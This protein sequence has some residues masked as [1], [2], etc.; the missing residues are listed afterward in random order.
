MARLTK[1]ES[2]AKKAKI[3]AMLATN[4]SWAMIVKETGCSFQTIAAI[5]NDSGN[6]SKKKTELD[7]RQA[8]NAMLKDKLRFLNAFFKDNLD[9]LFQSKK[10]QDFVINHQEFDEVDTLCQA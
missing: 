8:E 4:T 9:Y 7:S 2:E 1:L 10:I 5:R 6:H 3:A